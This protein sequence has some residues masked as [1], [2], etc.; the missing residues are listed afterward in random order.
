MPGSSTSAPRQISRHRGRDVRHAVVTKTEAAETRR[1]GLARDRLERRVAP[2][3]VRHL[4]LGVDEEGRA[5]ERVARGRRRRKGQRVLGIARCDRVVVEDRQHCLMGRGHADRRRTEQRHLDR[6][7]DVLHAVIDDRQAERLAG[8][9]DREVELA[10]DRVEV[11]GVDRGA[12]GLPARDPV[13]ERDV[14]DLRVLAGVTS[15][16]RD[17]RR[18]RRPR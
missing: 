2:R 5:G 3:R 12:L 18:P 10:L 13:A 16:D 6:L 15:L 11:V 14:A 8:H 17:P 1:T 9:S 4:A 7:R